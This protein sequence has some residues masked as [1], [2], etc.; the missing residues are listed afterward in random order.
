ARLEVLARDL[1]ELGKLVVDDARGCEL[2]GA[3]LEPNEL[4]LT[5]DPLRGRGPGPLRLLHLLR[6]LRPFRLARE[7]QIALRPLA[8]RLRLLLLGGSG[9][10]GVRLLLAALRYQVG[11][12]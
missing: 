9:L 11:E 12:L 2:R 7:R 3:D 1:D 4:L 5:P 6:L 10:L 8:L